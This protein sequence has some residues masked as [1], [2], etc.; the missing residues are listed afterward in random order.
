MSELRQLL[1]PI[2][3]LDIAIVAILIYTLITMVRGTRA[4][5]LIK[6]FVLLLVLSVISSSNM[7][8]LSTLS[9]VL[10]QLSIVLLISIPIIF[11][12]ELRRA[13]EHLGS[14]SFLSFLPFIS[15]KKRVDRQAHYVVSQLMPFLEESSRT[16]TGALIAIEREVGLNEYAATGIQID[17]HLSSQLL[18]NIFIV[19]TPLHDGAVILRNDVIV[20]ASCYLPLSESRQI[21]K[22]LGTRHRAGIGLSEVSDAVVCIVSEETGAISIAEGGQ[23]QYNMQPEQVRE[24]L[25]DRLN[26]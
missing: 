21:N 22:A 17:G 11:Q 16:R 10:D 13:L 15:K 7:L 25:L 26:A 9:W 24:A 2:N 12:P 8:G 23:L 14:G 5:Q 20:A 18:G 1:N 3:I 19:N 6:G 4:V